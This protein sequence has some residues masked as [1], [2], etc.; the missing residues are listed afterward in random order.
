MAAFWGTLLQEQGAVA[1][2]QVWIRASWHWCD[3]PRVTTESTLRA[4]IQKKQRTFVGFLFYDLL[5]HTV[6]DG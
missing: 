6:M 4:A 3:G 1:W 2:G 5:F